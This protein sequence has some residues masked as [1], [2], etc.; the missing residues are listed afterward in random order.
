MSDM[1]SII[2][3]VAIVLYIK[4]S[5]VLYINHGLFGIMVGDRVTNH[6]KISHCHSRQASEAPNQVIIGELSG[7]HQGLNMASAGHI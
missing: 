1:L 7:Y 5:L 2:G 3:Y 6:Y 4:L